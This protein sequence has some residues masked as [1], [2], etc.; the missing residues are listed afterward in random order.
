MLTHVTDDLGIRFQKLELDQ[1]VD[2]HKHNY[3]HLTYC[4]HG[5]LLIEKL[6]DDD[7]VIATATL[8][9]SN[10]FNFI[11]IKAGVK[12]RLTALVEGTIYHCIYVHRGHDGEVVD[13]YVGW[14]PAYE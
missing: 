5:K 13:R 6:D 7:N 3:D 12:H 14:E 8:D 4:P 9:S 11:E 10:E 1:V 2:A